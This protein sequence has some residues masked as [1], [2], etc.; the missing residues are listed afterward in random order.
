MSAVASG[1]HKHIDLGHSA[2]TG[3]GLLP[4]AS[5]GPGAAVDLSWL[6]PP[7]LAGLGKAALAKYRLV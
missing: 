5:P 7:R 4:T 1:R 6:L 2:N 3:G